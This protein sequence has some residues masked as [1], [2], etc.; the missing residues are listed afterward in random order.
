MRSKLYGITH[1][2][3]VLAAR[4]MLEHKG[5]EP[6]LRSIL[7]GLHP[8]VVRAAGF[9]GWTV[10]AL[11]LGDRRVI[12]TL[13]ISRA[14]DELVPDPPLF[15]VDPG[16]RS[17]V[18]CAERFGHDE[19][20]PLARRVFRWTSLESNEIRAWMAREVVGWP[21]PRLA[22]HAFKPATVLFGRGISKASHA[23]V[24][25]D[26]AG[27]P[28]KLD[29]ADALIEAGVIACETPNA[30]DFQILASLRLLLAHEDL[31]PVVAR[32]R[33]GRAALELIPS[34]PAPPPGALPPVPPVLPREWLP[35]AP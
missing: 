35:E 4:L 16:R 17:A 2:H 15:P 30:A 28:E 10:P 9:P 22:G 25:D 23:R 20:Q 3:A 18:E 7:P 24:R 12:G 29:R 13:A 11:R 5:L 8:L 31:M 14:L 34:F 6:E 1:S 27:L 19:L 26:L 21:L 32:W 33:C